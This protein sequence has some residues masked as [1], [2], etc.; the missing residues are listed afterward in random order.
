MLHFQAPVAE[1]PDPSAIVELFLEILLWLAK[2]SM[3]HSF[4]LNVYI[5]NCFLK[6]RRMNASKQ[7]HNQ[8]WRLDTA[9][10]FAPE[11]MVRKCPERN[12][13]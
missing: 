10:L 11:S 12:I 6:A 3:L 5:W 13:V 1:D 9:D 2:V 7:D 4:C 8:P